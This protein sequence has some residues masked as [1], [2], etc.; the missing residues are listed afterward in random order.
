[1]RI[2][3]HVRRGTSL[4]DSIRRFAAIGCETIQLFAANPSAW[5]ASEMNAQVTEGFRSVVAEFDLWPVVVHTQYLLNLASPDPEL[6][7]KSAF[8]L[9][10]NMLRA[11]I[12]GAQFVVTHIGSHK[13]SG[14]E[15]GIAQ[16]CRSVSGV[17]D[18]SPSG[19]TLLLENSA[20]A[21][22]SVGSNFLDL[23]MILDCLPDYH[24]RLGIC[25]DTAHLWGAGY[26]LSS[27]EAVVETFAAFDTIVGIQHLR[28][29]HTNDT[30]V[31]LGAKRDRHANIGTGNIGIEGFAAI[32][33]HPALHDIHAIIETPARTIED[34]RHDIQ[35]LKDLRV[36]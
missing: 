23:R 35:I 33:N 16:V 29:L 6:Q 36:D 3:V 17:L 5:R 28:L 21:G 11:H 32:V 34:D 19:V 1:M 7:G 30:K 14:S 8:A 15:Q 31:E 13:G 25:L 26:D 12:L 27:P 10:D 22:N 9:A 2:G 18:H 20:G 24:D 4:E